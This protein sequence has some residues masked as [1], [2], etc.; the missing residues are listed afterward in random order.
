VTSATIHYDGTSYLYTVTFTASD[1]QQSYLGTIHLTQR[2]T[3]DPN[4]YSG[5]L[6]FGLDDTTGDSI[7]PPHFTAGTVRYQRTSQTG[8]NISARVSYYPTGSHPDTDPGALDA[9]GELDPTYSNWDYSFQRFGASFDPTSQW[10]TGTYVFGSQYNGWN[11][12]GP[13][14]SLDPE[15]VFQA[16]MAGDGT[17]SAYYG[18]GKGI[19]DSA[20]GTVDHFDCLRDGGTVHHLNAQ[21][22]PSNSIPR[23]ASTCPAPRCP[24]PSATRPPAPAPTP[25]ISGITAST[26]GSGTTARCSIPIPIR[27]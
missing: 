7:N 18:L 1:F 4:V 20:A 12:F 23:A 8:L 25:S 2:P 5:I 26:P 22:S 19:A 27:P 16:V 24:R 6:Y 11:N 10:L 17:G 14:N 13:S 21:F 15:V 3:A 9:N